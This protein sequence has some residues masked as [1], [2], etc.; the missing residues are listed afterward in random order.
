MARPFPRGTR[1]E[2]WDTKE[3]G[4]ERREAATR[5]HLLAPRVQ[6]GAEAQTRVLDSLVQEVLQDPSRA[7]DEADQYRDTDGPLDRDLRQLL[8]PYR[9][10]VAGRLP[11]GN[12]IADSFLG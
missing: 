2:D 9:E 11:Q 8:P 6:E 4:F 7:G 10:G 12:S 5:G 3:V 1:R